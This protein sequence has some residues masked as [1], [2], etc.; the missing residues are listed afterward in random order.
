MQKG[1]LIFVV[2]GL[3]V[4]SQSTFVTSESQH[5]KV[6]A[7]QKDALTCTIC[8]T[9]IESLDETIIDPN[10]E[11]ALADLLAGICNSLDGQI[12]IM[13]QEF[14]SEFIDDILEMIVGNYLEPEIFCT[15][16]GVCP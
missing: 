2:L 13:C 11:Q 9:L 16:L 1:G 4:L 12:E 10:N 3:V 8:K 15:S 7:K 14:V 5:I 6:L